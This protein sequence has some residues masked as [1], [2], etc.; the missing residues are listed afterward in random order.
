VALIQRIE[1]QCEQLKPPIKIKSYNNNGKDHQKSN[2]EC[3]MYSLFFI[4]T[5]LTN[6]MEDKET[7]NGELELGFDEK[8]ALFRDAIIPDKYVEIYRHKYFNKPE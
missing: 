1:E 2:T 6:K 3:G 7:P 8:I 5:I 4:I